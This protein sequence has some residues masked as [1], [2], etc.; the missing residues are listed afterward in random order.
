MEL[1]VYLPSLSL[2]FEYQGIQHYEDKFYF[3]TASREYSQR[4]K[5]KRAACKEI[6]IT[7]IEVPYW[8]DSIL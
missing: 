1:D 4:D 3:G 5:E 2:A 8:W 6:G 7:L